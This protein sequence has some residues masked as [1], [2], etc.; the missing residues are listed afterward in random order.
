MADAP[1]KPEARRNMLPYALLVL[2]VGGVSYFLYNYRIEGLDKITWRPRAGGAGQAD[3]GSLP[4]ERTGEAIRIASFRVQ[5]LATVKLANSKTLSGLVGVIRRFD[6]VAIQGCR[7][8]RR[9]VLPMLLEQVNAGGRHYDFVAGPALDR[10]SKRER[11]AIFFD[12]GT[13]DIDPGGVYT[14]ND[15]DNLLAHD[16]LVAWFRVRGPAPE[17]AFTFTLINVDVAPGR[18][19]QELN[20]LANVFRAVRDD[21]RG[22]DDVIMAGNFAAD[23]KNLGL[24]GQIPGLDW[25]LAGMATTTKGDRQCD[26]ILFQ[27]PATTEFLGR[28]EVFDM[29]REFKLNKSEA[30]AVSDHLPIWAEFSIYEGAKKE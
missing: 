9:D 11:L 30:Q 15:P 29:M 27:Q 18:V 7:V 20:A 6:V 1:P 10:D 13:L 4:V 28:A 26:N 16:P 24:L 23:E 21:G 22:E 3:P 12:R 17:K 14:V 8:E 5:D 19:E 25:A 2:A